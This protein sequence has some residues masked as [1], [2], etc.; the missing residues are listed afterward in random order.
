MSKLFR[1]VTAADVISAEKKKEEVKTYDTFL[2]ELESIMFFI[3]HLIPKYLVVPDKK[4][5]MGNIDVLIRKTEDH[6][7]FCNY[8]ISKGINKNVT[9]RAVTIRE[10]VHDATIIMDQTR[11]IDEN[12]LKRSVTIN[13]TFERDPQFITI[14]RSDNGQIVSM[15]E[16][17]KKSDPTGFRMRH[18]GY[19]D[20]E[21]IEKIYINHG[22][23][24]LDPRQEIIRRNINTVKGTDMFNMTKYNSTNPQFREPDITFSYV[25]NVLNVSGISRLMCNTKFTPLDYVVEFYDNTFRMD[26]IAHTD[27]FAYMVNIEGQYEMIE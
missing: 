16:S 27:L 23:S 9:T 17:E 14:E 11:R 21:A 8:S 4:I 22:S 25:K 15:V 24:A 1:F 18:V 7:S 20:E 26:E 6:D 5:Y 19:S 2:N 10:S 12:T 3:E 13:N